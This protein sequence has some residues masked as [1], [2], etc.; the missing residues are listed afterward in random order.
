M[1]ANMHKADH[2]VHIWMWT[3]ISH[4]M[5]LVRGICW[6]LKAEI[7]DRTSSLFVAIK[8]YH[9]YSFYF[10]FRLNSLPSFELI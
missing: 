7:Q 6:I 2:Y 4:A 5:T 9:F 10:I 1:M 8:F 3:F